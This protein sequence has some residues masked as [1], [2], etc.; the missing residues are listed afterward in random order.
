M[1]LKTIL[2]SAAAMLA[3]SL[4]QAEEVKLALNGVNDP[5]KNAEAAFV[6]GFSDALKGSD[7]KVSVFPSG[8]L[9]KEKERF[10]QV[11]QG[12]IH[13]NLA[14]MS[15][16]YGMSPLMKGLALPF[17]FKGNDELDMLV[18]KSDLLKRMNVPLLKNGVRLSGLNY[19]GVPIGIH[20]KTRPITTL[21][22]LKGMRFRSLNAEMLAYQEAMGAKGTIIAWSEVANAIQTGIAEGYFNPPNSAIRTGHTEFL[23]HFTPANIAPSARA[24]LVSEDWYA[25]LSDNG[26]AAIDAA[27]KAGIAANRGWV[28]AWKETVRK[29]HI[30]AGVT[31][32]ELRGGERA[33]MA[34]AASTTWKDVMSADDLALFTGALDKLRK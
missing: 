18:E 28:D 1:K 33:K 16:G 26:K 20:N 12:L 7:F 31:I 23:V 29:R 10:D 25:G 2:L 6:K 15:T 17:M 22:D 13:V 34:E 14:T 19:I 11:A 3:A 8:T 24:V 5:S 27:I 9:G 30:E 32:S 21:A 4:V